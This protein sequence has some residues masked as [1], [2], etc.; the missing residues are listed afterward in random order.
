MTK[1]TISI[2]AAVTAV[3]SFSSCSVEKRVHRRGYHV[4]WNTSKEKG[5]NNMAIQHDEKA[6]EASSIAVNTAESGSTKAEIATEVGQASTSVESTQ[7]S[8]LI[9]N[10]SASINEKEEALRSPSIRTFETKAQDNTQT[11]LYTQANSE[12]KQAE[13]FAEATEGGSKSR[14]TALVLCFFLGA[15]GIHRFYLGYTGIGVLYLLTLGLF[16]F[17]VLVDFIRL[18][19]KPGLQ[20]KDGTYENE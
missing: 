17:G 3:I 2:L 15:L 5:Q 7:S 12:I 16:G 19:I 10:A 8:D 4:E 20:P 1:F 18:I 11:V 9:L 14:I 13:S 6:L